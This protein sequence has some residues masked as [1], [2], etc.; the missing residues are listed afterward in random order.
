MFPVGV[1]IVGVV[2]AGVLACR[3]TL[4]AKDIL[5]ESSDE[6][7]RIEN[8][9]PEEEI[10]KAKAQVIV[11][12][13]GRLTKVYLPSVVIGTASISCLIGS[14]NILKKRNV[15]LAAAYKVLDEGFKEYRGRVIDELGEEKD[16]EFRYGMKT[17]TVTVEET[18]EKGKTKKFKKEETVIDNDSPSIYARFF[19]DASPYWKD[20]A[21]MNKTFLMCQQNYANDLLVTRGHVFLNEILDMLG[22][23]RCA[24]GA[25]VGWYYDPSD[26]NRDNYIDFGIFDVKSEARRDFVNGYEKSILLDF[27]VDGVMYDLI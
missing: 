15:A 24:E 11:K 26:Q 22:L 2:T 4:E 23:P 6:I 8:Y 9:A 16:H 19:D 7:N 3:A 10:G 13:A 12:T 27:N 1:G 20:D 25:V 18:D 21:S 14:H 5:E 17:K